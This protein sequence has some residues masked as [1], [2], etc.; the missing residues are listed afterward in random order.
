MCGVICTVAGVVASKINKWEK[1]V[2]IVI[3]DRDKLWGHVSTQ[4]VWTTS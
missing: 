2:D 3:R 1:K 4:H